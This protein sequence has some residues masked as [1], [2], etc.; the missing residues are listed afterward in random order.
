MDQTMSLPDVLTLDEAAAYLR[1]PKET[2]E[3][4]AVKGHIPGR[5]I[6]DTWRFLRDA[7]D[8]WLRKQDSRA[9][10][11]Q[12]AGVLADDDTLEPLRASIYKE[13]GRPEVDLDS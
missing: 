7:I 8:E 13:R 11:L 10:L 6:E 1:I 12:Q 5:R 4:Q 3:R 9:I 2:V